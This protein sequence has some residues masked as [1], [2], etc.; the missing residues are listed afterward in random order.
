MYP[1]ATT[2]FLSR[3]N[4]MDLDVVVFFDKSVDKAEK[5]GGAGGSSGGEDGGSIGKQPMY[6]RQNNNRAEAV[7]EL[8]RLASVLRSC[9]RTDNPY[10]HAHSTSSDIYSYKS[11]RKADRHSEP[12]PPYRSGCVSKAEGASG[13]GGEAVRSGKSEPKGTCHTRPTPREEE[14]G[15]LDSGEGPPPLRLLW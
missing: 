14:G 6:Q 3:S 1:A 11:R 5:D 9:C 2:P 7:Y 10:A 15:E 12:I 4:I 13:G 8:Q